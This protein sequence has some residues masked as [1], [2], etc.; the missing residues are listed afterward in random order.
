[1]SGDLAG[2]EVVKRFRC[3]LPVHVNA[4]FVEQLMELFQ[5]QVNIPAVGGG[6]VQPLESVDEWGIGLQRLE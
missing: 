1:M 5:A 2:I 4:H 6:K 3:P